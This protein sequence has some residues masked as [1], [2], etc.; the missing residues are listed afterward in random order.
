MRATNTL[1]SAANFPARL[2]QLVSAAF[3]NDRVA[4]MKLQTEFSRE[5]RALLGGEPGRDWLPNIKKKLVEMK[6]IKDAAV[7]SPFYS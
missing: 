4:A 5:V 7:T 1:L 3:A 6:I 2:I